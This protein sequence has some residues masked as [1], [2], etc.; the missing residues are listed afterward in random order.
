VS[1]VH[2]AVSG[3]GHAGRALEF[4]EVKMSA[5]NMAKG[6]DPARNDKGSRKELNCAARTKKMSTRAGPWPA[7]TC[8][9]PGEAG[10]IRRCSRCDSQG[11]ESSPLVF[12]HAQ[13][14]LQRARRTPEILDGIELLKAIEGARLDSLAISAT[15]PAGMSCRWPSHVDALQIIGRQSSA[16]LDCAITLYARPSMVKRLT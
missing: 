4:Q 6:A 8:H 15:A 5:P 16:A 9:S 12:Q 14:V 1:Q 11:E 2:P 10:A 13:P 3:E 7:G